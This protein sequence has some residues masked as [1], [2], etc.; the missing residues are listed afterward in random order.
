MWASSDQEPIRV[1][2]EQPLHLH[3]EHP[4]TPAPELTHALI[5]NIA[6]TPKPA[7]PALNQSPPSKPN[8]IELEKPVEYQ[9]QPFHF[10]LN[11][12]RFKPITTKPTQ[13]F[14]K[15]FKYVAKPTKLVTEPTKTVA[16]P[17]KLA[18]PKYIGKPFPEA[19]ANL[20]SFI[21][22]HNQSYYE[23]QLRFFGW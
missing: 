7:K 12:F 20:D 4:L 14:A 15:Q 16:K 19:Y 13:L 2:S 8:Q 6:F 9:F 10:D 5:E 23:K 18:V 3:E 1:T 11:Q 22:D 21:K 17:N